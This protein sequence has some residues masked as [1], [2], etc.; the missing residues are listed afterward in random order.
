MAEMLTDP[1][2]ENRACVV[3]PVQIQLLLAEGGH[4]CRRTSGPSL[5]V[6]VVDGGRKEVVIEYDE[7]ETVGTRQGRGES[8]GHSSCLPVIKELLCLIQY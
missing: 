1:Q 4:N 8:K 6:S 5:L 3:M 2:Q 7:V